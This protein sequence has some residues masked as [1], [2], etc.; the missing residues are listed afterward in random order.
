[1]PNPIHLIVRLPYN[2]PVNPPREPTPV[3]WSAQKDQF[4]WEVL[5]RSRGPDS[6]GID[7]QGLANHLGT[8]LP[9]LLFRAQARY[10]ED[11][12]GLRDVTGTLALNLGAP[13]DAAAVSPA[14]TAVVPQTGST[15][16][17]QRVLGSQAATP[18][19]LSTR[20]SI[21]PTPQRLSTPSFG[22]SHKTPPSQGTAATLPAREHQQG[23]ESTITLIQKPIGPVAPPISSTRPTHTHATPTRPQ[24]ADTESSSSSSSES[25]GDEDE[26][27]QRRQDEEEAAR[28]RL[29]ELEKMMSSDILGFARQQPRLV[30]RSPA[31]PG[32]SMIINRPT[33]EVRTQAGN[34]PESS[35]AMIGSAASPPRGRQPPPPAATR[36]A[37]WQPPNLNLTSTT[38]AQAPYIY[39]NVEQRPQSAASS[40]PSRSKSGHGSIPSIPSPG[41]SQSP[42]VRSS[43]SATQSTSPGDNSRSPSFVSPPPRTEAS[44]AADRHVKRLSLDGAVRGHSGGG[45]TA[46][47][48]RG[49]SAHGHHRQPGPRTA[50][51][52]GS[53]ASSFSDISDT[54]MSASALE[55]ALMSN[56]N[57]GASSRLSMFA[58][59]QFR[60][61]TRG[62][63]QR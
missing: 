24:P 35:V 1:M 28:K 58:R 52:H 22:P 12:R 31:L 13:V 11:L 32:Q 50:S 30:T 3:E 46:G 48:S 61:A 42:S 14:R 23:S 41:E 45:T 27:A 4:L 47:P 53:S 44:Q 9:Y 26:E 18:R 19:V 60:G 17:M 10:E 56:I 5:S 29:Q 25:S 55:D 57:R 63:G 6:A 16:L 54:S 39:P 34:H 62:S 21:A 7:W 2:R 59:S 8:P 51:T 40:A 15:S 20:P 38:T 33:K 49:T 37:A 36:V 43:T